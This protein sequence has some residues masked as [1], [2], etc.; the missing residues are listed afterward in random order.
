MN[1]AKN[2]TATTLQQTLERYWGYTSFREG[3][4]AIIQ[5]VMDRR[6]TLA[7][8]P[9]GGGKSLTY[10]VPTLTREGLCIVVTPLIALMKDQVDRLR[11]MGIS[12]TAIHSGMS[13][14]Q[15][16]NALDNC[17]YGD[18]KFLYVAPERLA[19]EAFRM[20]VQRMKVSLLAVDEAHCIS[21]WGYDFRPSYLRIVELRQHLKDVP[22]LALT[23]SATEMVAKDIMH[24][25]DFQEP[26]I[27]RSSFARSNLS[28]AVR[29]TDDKQE[30]LLRII[31]NVSGSG[32]VYMRSREG[33]EQL[34]ETLRNQGIS[35]SYYHAGLPHAERS[36]R[37]EE[38]TT[39]KVRV[40]V[41]TNA[42]G[43]GIDK[44]D[45][46]FV[47][48][49]TMCDSLESYYQEA[50]RAGRDGE[51][52]YAVLL[53]SSDDSSKIT[54]RFDAEF[55][56]LEEVKS[57][58]EKICDYVQV[59][60]GDGL[61]ASFIFNIHDFCRRE[62]IYIGKVRAAINLLEQNGYLTLTEEMENPARIHF[63]ISRDELYRIRV[64]RNELDHIIRIILR[65]Y[66]GVFTEFRPIDERT[67][68]S[69]SGYT[70]ERVKELL[71]RM[72]QLRI[73]RYIPANSSPMLFF[74]EER[75]PTKDLYISPET[76]VHRKELMAERFENMHHYTEQQ[77]E[78]RS[79]VLQRYFGDQKAT[80][81]GTCDVCLAAKRREKSDGKALSESILDLLSREEMNIKELCRELKHSPEKVI[82]AV[83][84][85]KA[86]GKISA[87]IS[88]KLIII[89]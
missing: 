49:F 34:C 51:R 83:D 78:C 16:D 55:P 50:G 56:P 71:K 84:K 41:A 80:A 19:T 54:K 32:I 59:A 21:Q 13:Y 23:A 12:A 76:Y 48:H 14:T 69:T 58:Y 39:G 30:Q 33:C 2:I 47:V 79:V 61:Y 40:M 35:A 7:L 85:L 87:Q 26:N 25:L 73:I 9:T 43:M 42:F 82:A 22:V 29:H 75:L 44:A 27:L 52:S 89:E 66:N 3:Q 31:N 18:V 53:S 77:T 60:V 8:M 67:I 65:L 36:M 20:R 45:V 11:R 62:R 15:I 6:D 74:N 4:M 37:Q 1:D 86:E 68:A 72:W 46:R 57:I 81:C 10:Q 38:W 28:Y 24:H 70:I 17:V 5:S 88:G 64:G 63:C